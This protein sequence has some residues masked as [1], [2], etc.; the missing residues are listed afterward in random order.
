[1]LPIDTSLDY[2][3]ATK[4]LASYKPMDFYQISNQSP[5]N[6]TNR[7]AIKSSVQI[8]SS[9]WSTATTVLV[10]E[11][12]A[13]IG[14]PLAFSASE[15]HLSVEKSIL[16][17][18]DVYWVEFA[19]SPDE[20]IVEKISE[21]SFDV[22]ITTQNSTVLSLLPVRIGTDI[23]VKNEIKTPSVK[24]N[25]VEVG[26]MFS[27]TVE[28]KYLKPT[29]LGHGML[30]NKLGWI[31]K[32]DAIDASAK[33]MFAVLGIPHGAKSIDIKYSASV[34]YTTLFGTNLYN[35]VGST[36]SSAYSIPVLAAKR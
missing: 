6:S 35:S 36:G 16:R 9:N 14:T 19:I 23:A 18:Y 34:K 1:M 10:Q 5:D 25:D 11:G 2:N 13:G 15:K 7:E 21:L 17:Q 3:F 4:I 28:Y 31:F 29:I 20:D 8:A 26:E 30:T 22:S 12:Q 33:R 32:G 24:V 27:R